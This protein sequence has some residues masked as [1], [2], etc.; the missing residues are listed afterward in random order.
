MATDSF[1][2]PA[3]RHLKRGRMDHNFY[4]YMPQFSICIIRMVILDCSETLIK[5][6]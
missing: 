6:V 2:S 5:V 1:M 4:V 3:F